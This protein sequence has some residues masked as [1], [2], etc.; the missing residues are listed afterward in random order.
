MNDR[1]K[2]RISVVVP[3]K[4]EEQN[5]PRCLAALTR[6]AEI[7]VVDSQST[8]RTQDIARAARARLLDFSWNGLYP[9]K[10]NWVLVNQQLAAGWVLF[11]DADEIVNDTFCN[12]VAAAIAC[13]RHDGYWLNYTNYFL[14][15]QL[16]R[17]VPQRKLALFKVGKG[18]YEQIDEVSWSTL[19]MEIHEHPIVGGSV[20][21]IRAPI[22][23]NDFRGIEKFLDRHGEY[24]KWEARRVMLLER[25]SGL[26]RKGLTARQN[27]KYRNLTA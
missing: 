10:R 15:R 6:F 19:D 11:I 8:D 14:G 23:H 27:F 24:A 2:I 22:E 16:K 26:D 18:L 3:V 12:E 25:Q 13:G 20:G 7:V 17:G 4:N 5:L 1:T 21:E 9:K